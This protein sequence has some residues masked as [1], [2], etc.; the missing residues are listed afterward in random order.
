MIRVAA[1]GDTHV[2]IDSLGHI[3]PQLESIADHADLL[4]VAGD[5][6]KAGRPE[7]AEVFAQEM[8]GLPVP[9]VVVL[10][11][12]DHH[13]D[14]EEEITEIL[15]GAG[16]HVLECSSVTFEIGD[17]RVGVAG[18]KGF[19]GGFAGACGSEF[20]ERAMKAFMAHTN[21]LA[22]ALERELA[23]L[24]ADIKIA[25]LHYSP[26]RGTLVGERLEIYPFLGSHR[27][28]EAIDRAGAHLVVHGHAHLGTEKGVTPAGIHVRN[29]A[30]PV[31][32]HAYNVYAVHGDRVEAPTLA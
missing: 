22:S 24:D 32:G 9:V 27:L 16:V 3:R 30:L 1:V 17:L 18:T 10:G 29:V 5:L 20:G 21:G 8:A 4:L 6:T 28:A 19:G 7:E 26:I 13:H 23:S 2:G 11:N 31:I 25:L 15:A 14:A 12:H